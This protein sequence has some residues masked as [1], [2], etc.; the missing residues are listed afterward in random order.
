MQYGETAQLVAI[1]VGHDAERTQVVVGDARARREGNLGEG[2]V[3]FFSHPRGV[4]APGRQHP[5]ER[6]PRELG[7]SQLVASDDG[8]HFAHR[9]IVRALQRLNRL[10]RFDGSHGLANA[11]LPD[12][13]A[14]ER[15]DRKPVE[16]SV[17]GQAVRSDALARVGACKPKGEPGMMSL[18]AER[19]VRAPNEICGGSHRQEMESKPRERRDGRVLH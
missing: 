1:S 15:V 5:R 9:A 14:D 10:A 16:G 18:V 3:D 6:S 11:S 19:L 7:M 2:L 13:R 17:D 4:D 8:Q 12:Q